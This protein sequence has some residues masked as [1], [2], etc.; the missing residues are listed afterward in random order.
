M[1]DLACHFF[2]K[3]NLEPYMENVRNT[4]M[5]NL[6]VLGNL[7]WSSIYLNFFAL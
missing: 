4:L 1:H 6:F 3:V 5:E 2:K 7:I